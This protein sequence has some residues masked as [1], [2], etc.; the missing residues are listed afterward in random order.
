MFGEVNLENLPC[1]LLFHSLFSLIKFYFSLFPKTSKVHNLPESL[2]LPKEGLSVGFDPVPS[3]IPAAAPFLLRWSQ[4]CWNSCQRWR[5]KVFWPRGRVGVGGDTSPPVSCPGQHRG[6]FLEPR[7]VSH[8][9]WS[10]LVSSKSLLPSKV[11]KPLG[12]SSVF[13][14]VLL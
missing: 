2:L 7:F 13:R 14:D 12:L 11:V 8:C 4:S 5:L 3:P 9:W 10:A 6:I 1:F